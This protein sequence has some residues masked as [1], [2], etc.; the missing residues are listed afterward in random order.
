MLTHKI[1][2]GRVKMWQNRMYLNHWEIISEIC[3]QKQLQKYKPSCKGSTIHALIDV[4]DQIGHRAKIYVWD[5]LPVRP[6][7]ENPISL[8]R[9]I[10]HELLHCYFFP[11]SH[12]IDDILI[13]KIIFQ[14]TLIKEFEK[15][16][17]TQV[18][19]IINMV[20][21]VIESNRRN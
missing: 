20:A 19:T 17:D 12:F 14:K 2:N 6:T 15:Y 18:D 16:I 10:I 9:V 11:I 3:D 7:K 5:E 13:P 8:D 1:L 4:T 21:R